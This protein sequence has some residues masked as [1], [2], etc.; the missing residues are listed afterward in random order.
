MNTRDLN[1]AL[2]YIRTLEL[3]LMKASITQRNLFPYIKKISDLI[4][5]I[6]KD[7]LDNSTKNQEYVY[8]IFV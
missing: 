5:E 6:N 8:D 3:R 2:E 1:K 7:L 4:H